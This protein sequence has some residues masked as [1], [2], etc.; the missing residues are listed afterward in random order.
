M[1][2]GFAPRA[3]LVGNW[4][5]RLLSIRRE[6]AGLLHCIRCSIAVC[7]AFSA[8]TAYCG[9]SQESQIGITSQ[10]RPAAAVVSLAPQDEKYG[11]GAFIDDLS[12]TRWESLAAF[13][14]VTFQGIRNWNWGSSKSFHANPEGWFG[15]KTGSGGMDKLGHA[16]SAYAIADVL[17]ERL[18]MSGRNPIR[19]AVSAA[20]I[21]EAVMLYV[22]FFD[23]YSVDH[24]FSREDFILNTLGAGLAL[25]RH[26]NPELREKLDFRLEYLPS[27]YKG[28]RP[29]ADYA[30]QKYVLSIKLAG[31]DMIRGTPLRFLE[32]QTGYY[33]EGFSKAEREDGMT[34]NRRLFVGL[35][36]NVSELLLGRRQAGEPPARRG[37]RVFFEGIQVPHTAARSTRSLDDK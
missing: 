16:W 24:G 28:F 23:G 15:A 35:G 22:E 19:A 14:G 26:A 12:D 3:R 13:A 10:S 9:D 29:F 6:R 18:V 11:V 30:G 31:F 20:L 2:D 33:A 34:P 36:V 25:A 5:H 37:L 27:G 21:A 7:M 1:I 32:L 4:E 17:G 8:T